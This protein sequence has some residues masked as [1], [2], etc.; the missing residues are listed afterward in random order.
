MMQWNNGRGSAET[1]RF[2]ATPAFLD[3]INLSIGS[4]TGDTSQK[5][6]VAWT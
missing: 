5:L 4:R 2:R 3:R 6:K 1:R